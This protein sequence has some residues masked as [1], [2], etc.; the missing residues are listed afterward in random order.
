MKRRT[1]NPESAALTVHDALLRMSCRRRDPGAHR[2]A[3]RNQG[4]TRDLLDPVEQQ[5][6]AD[7]GPYAMI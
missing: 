1:E 2:Y 6:S 3:G 7:H 5:E 4:S